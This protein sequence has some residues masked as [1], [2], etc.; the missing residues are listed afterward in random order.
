M[1]VP[2]E[3]SRGEPLIGPVIELGH[4]VG[5]TIIGGAIYR[6]S[7]LPAFNGSYIFGDWSKSFIGSGDGSILVSTPPAGYGISRYP[8]AVNAITPQDNQ[9]W[10]TQEFSIATNPTE[11]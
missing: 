8:S 5:N 9:M 2:A 3:G 10:T 7:S 6:G 4:D 11:G 1:P